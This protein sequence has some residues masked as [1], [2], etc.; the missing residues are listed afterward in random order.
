CLCPRRPTEHRRWPSRARIRM[1]SR[2]LPRDQS[3][4]LR[5]L[6]QGQAARWFARPP[7]RRVPVRIV[8][9]PVAEG[10]RDALELAL[11]E[12]GG[13]PLVV[14]A[15]DEDRRPQTRALH[16]LRDALRVLLG[17][18]RG[19]FYDDRIRRHPRRNGHSLHQLGRRYRFRIARTAGEDQD[20][21]VALLP[22]GDRAF[23]AGAGV[24]GDGDDGVRMGEWIGYVE[25]MPDTDEN[26][27]DRDRAQEKA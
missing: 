27:N 4:E 3:S 9:G 23:R 2:V 15:R 11:E 18:G 21:R 1:L 17:R 26:R 5:E 14:R 8:R 12:D 16:E 24:T 13:A 10:Q 22:E 25:P 20:R 7:E 19:A 6:D